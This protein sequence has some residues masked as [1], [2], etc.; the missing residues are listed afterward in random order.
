VGTASSNSANC[1]RIKTVCVYC[2]SSELSPAIYHTAA[3][4]L[5]THLAECDLTIVYG[6][7]SIGSMGRLA[8]AALMTGGRVIGVLPR[9]M[10]ELDGDTRT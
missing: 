5:G 3:A 8:N 2:A 7:G 10:D 9:F 6:G 1:R 4:H